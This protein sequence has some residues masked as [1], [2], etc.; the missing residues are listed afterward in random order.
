MELARALD[1]LYAATPDQFTSRRDAIIKEMKAAGDKDAAAQLAKRRKPT[2]LAH[3]LNELARKHPDD[4]AS[5]VDVGRDLARAHRKALRGDGAAELTKAIAAQ[6]T[7]V[8]DLTALAHELSNDDVD[9]GEVAAA[10]QAALVD[11]AAA[12]ALEEGQLEKAPEAP[13]MVGFA[14]D[15]IETETEQTRPERRA[16]S[17]R[18]RPQRA[19]AKEDAKR[20]AMEKA[21]AERERVKRE[22]ADL[23]AQADR[24]EQIASE[25]AAAAKDL[26]GEAERL[27]QAARALT[28]QAHVARDEA[29]RAAAEAKAA[30][31]RAP[32]K[33]RRRRVR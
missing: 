1:E 29:E 12:A 2:R 25:R 10:L 19:T 32:T 6:R 9:I 30:R 11:P 3:L 15:T 23:A 14:D 26:A 17:S 18:E 24:L 8:K 21:K 33:T 16:P 5:F 13:S 7:A 31:A 4:V 22:R 27:E 20:L 28:E